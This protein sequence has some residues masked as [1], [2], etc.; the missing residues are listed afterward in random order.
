VEIG[1]R[2]GYLF[3][4]KSDGVVMVTRQT[5]GSLKM[6]GR[7]GLA[8]LA[9]A[10]LL[11]MSTAAVGA[12]PIPQPRPAAPSP[13]PP[14]VASPSPEVAAWAKAVVAR[15]GRFKFYPP[16]AR[17]AS[18]VVTVRVT[19]DRQGDV[20]GSRIVKSSRS[21]ALDAAALDIFRRASPLP[22]PP[23]GANITFTVPITYAR[24][25]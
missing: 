22:A 20:L 23:A 17:G 25:G 8:A 21:A 4:N 2:R 12:Q 13:F 18:G 14:P 16:Q 10:A 11:V 15:L 3:S 24:R 1:R 5:G 19:V 7:S 6:P 9:A